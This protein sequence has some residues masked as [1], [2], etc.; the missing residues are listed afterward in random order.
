MEADTKNSTVTVKGVFDPPKIVDHLH[1]RAGKHS[2]ILKQYEE[3]KPKKE[4][5]KETPKKDDI[6]EGIEELWGNE[7]DSNLFYN[8]SLYPYQYLYSYQCF[9]EEN[10][11]ACSIL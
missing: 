8:H 4:K 10:S 2:V 7:N 5:V 9:S 6:K 3:K 11:N 1:N